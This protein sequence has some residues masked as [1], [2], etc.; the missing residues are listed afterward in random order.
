MKL[1]T[2]AYGRLLSTVQLVKQCDIVKRQMQLVFSFLCASVEERY[3]A[4]KKKNQQIPLLQLWGH[5]V[6]AMGF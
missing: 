5:I 2:Y 4:H 3:L 1:F 6:Q